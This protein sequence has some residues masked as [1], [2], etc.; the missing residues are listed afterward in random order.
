M[1]P[2]DAAI[3]PFNASHC[4]AIAIGFS[5][6][7]LIGTSMPTESGVFCRALGNT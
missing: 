7:I 3:E 1:S 4:T 6:W 2:P 5:G